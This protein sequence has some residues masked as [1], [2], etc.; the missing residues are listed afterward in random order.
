[1][2]AW[3][4]L[5]ASCYPTFTLSNAEPVQALDILGG[6]ATMTAGRALGFGYY[7]ETLG[8]PQ[9]AHGDT[10]LF[11]NDAYRECVSGCFGYRASVFGNVHAPD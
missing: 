8:Q 9:I 1:L 5:I 3:G 10:E 11:C 7:P 2:V 6:I 4:L